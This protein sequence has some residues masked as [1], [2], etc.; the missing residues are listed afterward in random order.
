[1]IIWRRWL[2]LFAIFNCSPKPGKNNTGVL[3][4]EFVKGYVSQA[5]NDEEV[6]QG[7]NQAE[8]YR[9]NKFSSMEEAVE[10]FKKSESV[11]LAMPLYCY[12]MPGGVKLFVEALEPLT[13]KCG[14]KKLGFL[15]QYGFKE[16]IHARPL[17]K[18][19]AKLSRRLGCQYLG[20]IIKGGCDNLAAGQK[21]GADEI[22]KG[23]YDI[24]ATLNR[25]GEFD[26]AELDMFSQPEIEEKQSVVQIEST[27]A[28]ANKYYWGAA[29][30]RNGISVEE[31]YA[32]PLL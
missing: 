8:I 24:G 10:I 32:R 17:E 25:K 11:L 27:L 18:Y 9:L 23:I 20:T 28:M 4:E 26:K 15:V 5:Q 13:G 30:A 12:A 16:G 2:K 21:S 22:L 19:L 7:R 31:S 1:M 14:G 3:L 6:S 29:L